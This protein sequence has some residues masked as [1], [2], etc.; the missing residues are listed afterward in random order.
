MPSSPLRPSPGSGHPTAGSRCSGTAR[1]IPQ[2]SGTVPSSARGSKPAAPP[3]EEASLPERDPNAS[4][5][6]E[7]GEA[8]LTVRPPSARLQPAT[9]PAG[10]LG[11]L[12]QP[13]KADR[14]LP[15]HR[16]RLGAE[17][18]RRCQ[19]RQRR[20]PESTAPPSP[21]AA[22]FRP[23]SSAAPWVNSAPSTAIL[24][25]SRTKSFEVVVGEIAARSRTWL[26]RSP[27][28][29]PRFLGTQG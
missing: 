14:C 27:R 20:R 28:K 1:G 18:S 13:Q 25:V 7:G 5:L 4:S 10:G 23:A 3:I 24:I 22:P 9:G 17:P 12:R 6:K 8:L 19:P 29:Q 15:P 21:T 2:P 16:Q 26:P 11:A